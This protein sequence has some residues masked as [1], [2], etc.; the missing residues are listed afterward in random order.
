MEG[1][2]VEAGGSWVFVEDLAGD[3]DFSVECLA[4]DEDNL[5]FCG[6]NLEGEPDLSEVFDA[7]FVEDFEDLGLGEALDGVEELL[8]SVVFSD[9]GRKGWTTIDLTVGL[10]CCSP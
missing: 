1:L 3:R 5:C 6:D 4:V 10:C 8:H 2:A 7:D 9:K